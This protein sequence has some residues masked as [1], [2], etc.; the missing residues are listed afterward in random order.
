MTMRKR[1][2]EWVVLG[3]VVGLSA[4]GDDA[5]SADDAAG[6]GTGGGGDDA[7]AMCDPVGATPEVGALLNAPVAADVEVIQKTPQ[8]PGAPGPVDLP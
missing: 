4:C 1:L 3:L 7:A 6:T 5:G 2:I 8:H